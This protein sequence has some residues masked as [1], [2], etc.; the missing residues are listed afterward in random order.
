MTKQLA[1]YEKRSFDKMNL[2]RGVLIRL[3]NDQMRHV[4]NVSQAIE[5]VINNN[6]KSHEIR[7]WDSDFQNEKK[8][9]Y[10][11]FTDYD[12]KKFFGKMGV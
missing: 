8:G 1:Y 5:F 2:D 12:M 6:I 7:L 10:K 3:Y 4:F 9:G 11:S